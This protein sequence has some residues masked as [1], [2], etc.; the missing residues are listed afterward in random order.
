MDGSNN[1]LA[2]VGWVGASVAVILEEDGGI[3]VGLNHPVEVGHERV[4]GASAG[5]VAGTETVADAALDVAL[6]EVEELAFAAL[7]TGDVD[8]PALRVDEAHAIEGFESH[9]LPPLVVNGHGIGQ[10]VWS[11]APRP[12]PSSQASLAHSRACTSYT[13]NAGSQASQVHATVH[14]HT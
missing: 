3:V 13:L 4:I 7:L 12:M 9:V 8:A 11:S 5:K 2:P 6:S 1:P 10:H 14:Q